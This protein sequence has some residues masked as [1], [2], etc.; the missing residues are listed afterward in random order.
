MTDLRQTQEY[1]Q[2]LS[3]IGWIVEQINGSYY[4]IKKLPL[5]GSILKVQRPQSIDFKAIEKLTKKY[6]VIKTIV[7]PLPNQ[8]INQLTNQQFHLSKNYFLPTKTL[9]IDLTKSPKEILRQMS[10][11]TRYNIRLAQKKNIKIHESKDI[12]EF[13]S[14]WQKNLEKS[15]LPFFSQKKNIIAL[16]KAFGNKANLL[17]A[18][19]AQAGKNQN[20]IIAGLLIF[21]T[22]D[23]AHYMYAAANNTGRQ[24]FAPTLLTWKGI[25]LAKKKKCK[26]FDFSG[27]YDERFPLKSWQGFTKFKK[28]FG[29]YEV[30]YPGCFLKNL[31]ILF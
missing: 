10:P 8:P 15:P 6:T 25:L 22:N 11:K 18:L 28:G 17:I 26:I 14:F 23:T 9:Q 13:T 24:L 3:S 27:I 31:K 12:A 1:A 2:Y 19:P 30:E 5:I 16:F 7:E 21:R 20:Q 4:F 29:G